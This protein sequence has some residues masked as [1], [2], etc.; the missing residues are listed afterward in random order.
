MGG[1]KRKP[2]RLHPRNWIEPTGM[3]RYWAYAQ[4]RQVSQELNPSYGLP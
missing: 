1:A 4:G 3:N 2:I